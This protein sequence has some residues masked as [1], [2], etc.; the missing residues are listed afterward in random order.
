MDL[1]HVSDGMRRLDSGQPIDMVIKNKRR[2]QQPQR[3]LYIER[4]PE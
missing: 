4:R 3:M 2:Q 1:I